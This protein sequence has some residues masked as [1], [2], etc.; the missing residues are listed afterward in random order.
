MVH[1]RPYHI[2]AVNQFLNQVSNGL[3]GVYNTPIYSV[4]SMNEDEIKS[5]VNKMIA[6][7]EVDV[8]YSIGLTCT[9]YASEVTKQHNNFPLLFS[10]VLDPVGEEII[11]S[12]EN[13]GENITGATFEPSSTEDLVNG[14]SALYPDVTSIFIP[15]LSEYKSN[16]LEIQAKELQQK[17]SAIG[18]EVFIE[19]IGRNY[20]QLMELV[21]K[22]R[23]KVSCFLLLDGCFSSVAQK[24]I[25]YIAWEECITQIGCSSSS[26]ACGA[27]ITY[28]G[29]LNPLSSA[30]YQQLETARKEQMPLG[31]IPIKMVPNNREFIINV[32]MMRRIG[33]S[34]E[35]LERICKSKGISATIRLWTSSS[36]DN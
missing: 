19:P 11:N 5:C 14:I 36:Q 35:S 6:R 22:Y 32:D 25:A 27:A 33:Y 20:D 15:Y 16:I 31:K 30:V 12:L 8:V 13:P 28:S 1:G 34:V 24:P 7:K 26:M 3:Q 17:L 29:D 9:A 2:S 10:G 18:M 23:K 4:S 21:E